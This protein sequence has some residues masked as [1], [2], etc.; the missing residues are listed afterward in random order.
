MYKDEK[1]QDGGKE[2]VYINYTYFWKGF[3]KEQS[4]IY[5]DTNLGR[6]YFSTYKKE[7]CSSQVDIKQVNIDALEDDILVRFGITLEDFSKLTEK[8]YNML[9]AEKRSAGVYI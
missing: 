9:K 7:W 3:R 8:K 2:R 4:G 6:L 5:V 1:D